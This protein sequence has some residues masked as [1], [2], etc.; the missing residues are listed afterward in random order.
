MLPPKNAKDVLRWI[1]IVELI[2]LVVLPL[3]HLR[4]WYAAYYGENCVVVIKE[5]SYRGRVQES[6]D[7]YC[8]FDLPDGLREVVEFAVTGSSGDLIAILFVLWMLYG[9]IHSRLRGNSDQ[10]DRQDNQTFAQTMTKLLSLTER[11]VLQQIGLPAK[12][13]HKNDTKQHMFKNVFKTSRKVAIT[14]RQGRA[15]FI[16]WKNGGYPQGQVG[17]PE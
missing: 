9:L 16:Q 2:L 15:S 6:E 8:T 10:T 4:I 7:L 17:H 5:H 12:T 14:F 11:E 3:E 1:I 13:I